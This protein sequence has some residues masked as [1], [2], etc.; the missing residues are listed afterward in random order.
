MPIINQP[1]VS[2]ILPIYNMEKFLE[3]CVDSILAQTYKNL[4][5]IL[6]NDGSKDRTD[7][8]CKKYASLDKR[9]IYVSQK[10]GGLCA[11]RNTGL[12]HA[13]GDYIIFI[14]P[15]DYVA[16]NLVSDVV[17]TFKNSEEELDMVAYGV[18]IVKKDKEIGQIFWEKSLTTKQILT[19]MLYVTGWEVWCKAYNKAIWENLRFNDSMRSVE[20]VYIAADI[21]SKVKHAKVLDGLYYYLDRQPHGSLTQ[22]RNSYSYYEEYIAW[23]HHLDFSVSAPDETSMLNVRTS[24]GAL[25]ALFKDD[26]DHKLSAGQREELLSFLNEQ[27]Y[28]KEQLTPVLL[29]YLFYRRAILI[30]AISG[31]ATTHDEVVNMKSALK[32]YAVNSVEKQLSEDQENEIYTYIHDTK[33]L[34]L[35]NIYKLLRLAIIHDNRL[36]KDIVGQLMMKKLSH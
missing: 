13:S 24:I 3:R 1:K 28:K 5:I 21:A 4:E 2:L 33:N 34:P 12:D 31:K 14:D 22:T 35:K 6:V 30:K 36:V 26:S 16:A 27:G 32:L 20:D 9:V 29:S 7:E 10:N 19:R 15:D 11:A 23:H 17:Q 8:I 18:H 25:R